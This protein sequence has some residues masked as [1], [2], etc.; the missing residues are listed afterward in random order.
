MLDAV[1]ASLNEF[2]LG[3]ARV[4]FDA[5]PEWAS[6]ARPHMADEV[7]SGAL[8]VEVKPPNPKVFD[9][10]WI[11]TSDD[12]VTIGFDRF[13]SHCSDYDEAMAVID[14]IVE[15]RFVALIHM[16]GD[17]WSGSSLTTPD[18]RQE[19]APDQL[20]YIRSWKGTH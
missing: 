18:D 19:E 5:Y 20:V 7:A 1:T 3:F 4:L 2:S 11:V 15:E 9:G 6:A 17:Q 14:G 12:E 13:H 16:R 8:L 10:F